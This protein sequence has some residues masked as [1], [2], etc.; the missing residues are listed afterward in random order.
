MVLSDEGDTQLTEIL[1]NLGYTPIIRTS[2]HEA[3]N[4]LRHERFAA[5]FV[6]SDYGEIDA[7]EFILNAR[8]VDKETPIAVYG[9]ST[10]EYEEK[11]IDKQPDVYR[12]TDV[13]ARRERK[14]RRFLN[15]L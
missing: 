3:I 5:V 12:L 11:F 7:L 13:P 6:N 10:N 1:F 15:A 14:I 4:K 9:G 2:M 8:D